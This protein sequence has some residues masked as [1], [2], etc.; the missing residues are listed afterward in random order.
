MRTRGLYGVV[1]ARV[2]HGPTHR[3]AALAHN[4]RAVRLSRHMRP[5]QDRRASCWASSHRRALLSN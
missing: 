5:P 1:G 3:I 2:R 4:W